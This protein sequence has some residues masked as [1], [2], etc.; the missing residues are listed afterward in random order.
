MLVFASY[1]QLGECMR[2]RGARLVAPT[3]GPAYAAW[4]LL[5][6]DAS[7]GRSGKTGVW[8]A[9]VFVDLD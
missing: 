2:L 7:D 3:A 1:L 9:A 4:G 6:R 8:D 5:L